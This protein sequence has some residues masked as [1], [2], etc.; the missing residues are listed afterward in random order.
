MHFTQLIYLN[1]WLR[2]YIIYAKGFL[3]S[4]SN[5]EMSW[6]FTVLVII[7]FYSLIWFFWCH[8]DF[9]NFQCSSFYRLYNPVFSL[10]TY[11]V[12]F[13]HLHLFSSECFLIITF[14]GKGNKFVFPCS[15]T[16]TTDEKEHSW[17]L[18]FNRQ[19]LRRFKLQLLNI[20][21]NVTLSNASIAWCGLYHLHSS[22]SYRGL[23]F[24]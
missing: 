14:Y 18:S 11:W 19:L 8:V 1:P 2:M 17:C 21:I 9:R 10:Y 16:S 7:L 13:I 4:V 24:F 12:M 15:L 3:Y 23:I 6:I 20:W 5:G 22:Y